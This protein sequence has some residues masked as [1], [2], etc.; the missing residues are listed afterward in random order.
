M[1]GLKKYLLE[2]EKRLKKIKQVVD[3]RLAN[4]PEGNLRIT[5]SGKHVQYMQCKEK[6]GKYHKQGEYIKKE[7]LS[8]VRAL[9]QKTYD[10]KVKRLVDRRLRQI[11]IIN[12]D[13]N[14][15]EIEMIFT[16]MNISR[17]EFVDPVE[18]TWEQK[19]DDWK[20]QPYIGKEFKEGTPEIYTK[21][22][23]RVRS[24]SEK[25][26]A[27]TLFDMGIEYKYE[28]P[29]YLKGY[30]TVYPD[31]TILSPK[32]GKEIYWEHDGRMDDIKYA[33]KAVKKINSYTL[34]GIIPGDRLILTFET[35]NVVLDDRVIKKMI[36]SFIV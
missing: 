21:K 6:N 25:L 8:L 31:F 15:N 10:Q 26:I 11:Q 1:T 30:G 29:L 12:K 13:Y 4:V 36:D 20:S 32:T 3:K 2:E 34:N 7:D 14:D 24:K 35:S 9:A 17:Q 23:E 5:S 16:N 28:C 22:G 18:K 19:L 33:Q 27:D